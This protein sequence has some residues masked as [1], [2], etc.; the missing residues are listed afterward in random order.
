[1]ESV[2]FKAVYEYDWSSFTGEPAADGGVNKMFVNGVPLVWSSSDNEW[3]YGTKLDDSGKLTFVVTGVEDT[4][5]KLTKFFDDAGSQSITWEKPFFETVV[6][7]LSIGA[8]LVVVAV[9]V[10]LS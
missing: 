10:I 3:K 7:M 1:M 4:Q 5:D 9:V 8:F 2:W 6:G